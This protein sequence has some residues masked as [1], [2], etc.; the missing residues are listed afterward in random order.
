MWLNHVSEI[1]LTQKLVIPKPV[2]GE[3]MRQWDEVGG[4]EDMFPRDCSDI[5]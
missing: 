5:T 2:D 4:N 3:Q 1:I